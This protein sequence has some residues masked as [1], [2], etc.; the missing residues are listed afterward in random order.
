MPKWLWIL[1][2]VVEGK[3]KKLTCLNATY[4]YIYECSHL[5]YLTLTIITLIIKHFIQ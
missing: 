2:D 3:S 5:F 1:E 4:A